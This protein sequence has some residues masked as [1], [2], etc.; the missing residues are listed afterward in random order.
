MP[1]V[2][3]SGLDVTPI[4][5]QV[6]VC[7]GSSAGSLPGWG[8]TLCAFLMSWVSLESLEPSPGTWQQL[9]VCLPT[10]LSRLPLGRS[11][12]AAGRQSVGVRLKKSRLSS[13]PRQACLPPTLLLPAA[14]EQAAALPGVQVI[15]GCHLAHA[16]LP[17]LGDLS[18][19]QF[20]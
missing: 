7:H 12:L 6:G 9:L 8:N 17:S 3:A 20:L 10:W 16:L 4:G 5:D 18:R 2:G 1:E 11:D 15:G 14:Q 13:G 19:G